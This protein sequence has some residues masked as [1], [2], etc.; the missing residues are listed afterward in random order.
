MALGPAA[1]G[2]SGTQKVVDDR[3]PFTFELPQNLKK[4]QLKEGDFQGSRPLFAYGVDR[5]NFIDVRRHAARQLPLA[6]VDLEVKRIL[7]QRGSAGLRS[8]RE[9]HGDSDMVVF[10]EVENTVGGE[11]PAGKRTKSKLYFFAGGGGTWEIECQSTED[12]AEA[13]ADGCKKAVDSVSFM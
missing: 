1:C 9:K 7:S 12:Q 10:E 11:P 2:S 5:L 8:K 13:I 6:T 3:L 4:R